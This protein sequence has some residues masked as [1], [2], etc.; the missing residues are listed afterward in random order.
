M[1]CSINIYCKSL[2]S[3]DHNNV[4]PIV[5]NELVV[6]HQLVDFGLPSGQLDLPHGLRKVA[7]SNGLGVYI[8][9]RWSP[10]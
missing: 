6:A 1:I 4:C 5:G 3:C 2:K 9:D 10:C 8:T 7:H